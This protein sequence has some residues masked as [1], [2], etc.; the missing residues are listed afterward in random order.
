MIPVPPE[1]RKHEKVIHSRLLLALLTRAPHHVTAFGANL[2]TTSSRIMPCIGICDLPK[3]GL[4][5]HLA[6]ELHII[7]I[8]PVRTTP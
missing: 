4:A 5:G 3:N 6:F 2:P 8:Q 1:E 7:S